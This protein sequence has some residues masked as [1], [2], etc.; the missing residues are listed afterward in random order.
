M[1]RLFFYF[2]RL[3]AVISASSMVI[4]MLVLLWQVISRYLLK[5]PSTITEELS[6]MLLIFM[7][8][9]GAVLSFMRKRHLALDL[10]YQR[11]SPKVQ[12][13]LRE[14]SAVAL[15]ILGFIFLLGGIL[16]IKE[17]WALGQ[18]TAVL[19]FELKYFYF[20]IPFCGFLI[21]ISPFNHPEEKS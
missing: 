10:L 11:S 15:V 20:I 6:R 14:V 3:L 4:L 1:R 2:D 13:V 17:K 16:L 8:S 7:G 19:G 9:T 21:M 18:T 5:N 12:K